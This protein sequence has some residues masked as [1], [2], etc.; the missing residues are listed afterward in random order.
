MRAHARSYCVLHDPVGRV[1]HM[2]V[3]T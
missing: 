3:Q 2:L 1:L